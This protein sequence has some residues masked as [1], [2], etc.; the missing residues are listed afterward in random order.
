MV[1]FDP[2]GRPFKV[3]TE[4]FFAECDGFDH[5]IGLWADGHDLWERLYGEDGVIAEAHYARSVTPA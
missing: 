2:N 1:A 4:A 5:W 3:W